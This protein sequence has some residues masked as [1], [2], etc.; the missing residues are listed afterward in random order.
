[1][2]AWDQDLLERTDAITVATLIEAG[3]VEHTPLQFTARGRKWLKRRDIEKRAANAPREPSDEAFALRL[4]VRR[5]M[6]TT[7]PTAPATTAP[8]ASPP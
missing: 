2:G 5:V 3:P 4:A 8:G 1:M 7:E 6:A